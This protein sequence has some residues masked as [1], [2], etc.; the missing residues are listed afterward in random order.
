MPVQLATVK[1]NIGFSD[2]LHPVTPSRLPLPV[3]RVLFQSSF[4]RVFTR[5]SHLRWFA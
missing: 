5:R 1:T 4:Q 2:T 3:M